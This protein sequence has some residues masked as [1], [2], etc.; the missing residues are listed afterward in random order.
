MP[1]NIVAGREQR[2]WKL[3]PSADRWKER[4][5]TFFGIAEAM[6]NQ[7]TLAMRHIGLNSLTYDHPKTT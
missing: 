4:S 5:R 1:S 3:P 7:W 6:A 2:I